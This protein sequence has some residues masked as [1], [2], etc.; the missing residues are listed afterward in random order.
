MDLIDA[1]ITSEP[2]G[3][4]LGANRWAVRLEDKTDKLLSLLNSFS[5]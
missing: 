1:A 2:L 4:K 5:D 3:K